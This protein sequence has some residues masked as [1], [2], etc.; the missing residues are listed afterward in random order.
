ML[1]GDQRL[2]KAATGED[3]QDIVWFTSNNGMEYPASGYKCAAEE[4][5]THIIWLHADRSP[6]RKRIIYSTDTDV[7]HMVSQNVGTT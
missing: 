4:D 2:F 1:R 7:Y 6:L 3:D 5:D